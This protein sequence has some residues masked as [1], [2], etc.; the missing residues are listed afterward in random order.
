MENMFD[1]LSEVPEVVDVLGAPP[2][3]ITSSQIE[4]RNVTFSYNPDRVILKNI[5]FT[6]PPGKTLALVCLIYLLFIF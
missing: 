1:L 5:S 2:L 4:F 6:V 3:R